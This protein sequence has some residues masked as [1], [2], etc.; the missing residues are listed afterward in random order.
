MAAGRR[1]KL[2]GLLSLAIAFGAAAYFG[3]GLLP[4]GRAGAS[5][6]APKVVTKKQIDP[7]AVTTA[8]VTLR[9]IERTVEIVGTLRGYEEIE[10]GANI[11][12][13]VA[14]IVHEV[15]DVVRP[16][17]MLLE[18]DD[19]DYRLAVEEMARALELE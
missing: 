9:S 1:K 7:I 12:G 5:T 2:V 18:I 6:P 16:G 8:P 17:E 10:V 11:D 13:R 14:R 15:G 3:R 4:L 19:T